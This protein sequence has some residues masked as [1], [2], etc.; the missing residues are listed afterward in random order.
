MWAVSATARSG[1]VG[2]PPAWVVLMLRTALPIAP[3]LSDTLAA[4]QGT[5]HWL[6]LVGTVM[7]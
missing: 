7:A 6:H 2:L 5:E 3:N 4:L 1:R